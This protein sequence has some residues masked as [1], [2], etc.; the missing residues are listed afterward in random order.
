[1]D[2]KF[3]PSFIP[4]KQALPTVGMAGHASL[5]PPRRGSGI[6]MIL[7]VIVFVLSL[8]SVAGAYFWKQYLES[9]QVTYKAELAKQESAFEPDVINQLKAINDEIDQAKSIMKSHVAVSQ[10]FDKVLQAVTVSNIGFLSMDLSSPAL[11]SDDYALKLSGYGANLA[12]VAFQ[13]DVLGQ[14]SDYGL[15]GVVNNPSVSNPAL[16]DKGTTVT[17][18]LAASINPAGLSYEQLVNPTA[19][20]A[21]SSTASP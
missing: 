4:K 1:M 14:L 2:P 8:L 7:A 10:I 17:F 18:D 20:A 6:F 13:S 19:P 9:S 16:S 5:R 3:Q 12:A 11:G 15:T 21:A